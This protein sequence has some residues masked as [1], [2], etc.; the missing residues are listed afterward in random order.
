M[1]RFENITILRNGVMAD[2]RLPNA[3]FESLSH[4][5]ERAP[6]RR[7]YERA[8]AAYAAEVRPAALAKIVRAY[9]LA[10][11]RITAKQAREH[12][13]DELRERLSAFG[14]GYYTN[15]EIDWH[16]ANPGKRESMLYA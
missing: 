16:I 4:Y 8:V 2:H 9:R 13:A 5:R 14:Q 6:E 1:T 15:A 3:I 11:M 10:G 7:R 12:A